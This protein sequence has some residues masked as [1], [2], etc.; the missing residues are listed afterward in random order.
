MTDLFLGCTLDRSLNCGRIGAC[1]GED[2]SG[3]FK[4]CIFP[5]KSGGQEVNYCIKSNK[6]GRYWCATSVD[7]LRNYKDWGY[8]TDSCTKDMACTK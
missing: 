3:G 8:C 6:K 1:Q 5:F 4:P 2:A 7:N